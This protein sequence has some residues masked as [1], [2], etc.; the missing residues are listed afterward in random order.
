MNLFSLAA[1]Q[2]HEQIVFCH[3]AESGLKA[4]IG[5]HDTTLGPALGGCRM[6]PYQSEEAALIDVLRLSRGMTYKNAVMGLSHGGGK[7]VIIGDPR[8]DKSPQLWQAFGRF[9]Q[10]LGGRYI[11][12]EDVGVSVDD[13]EH[14][15]ATTRWV[16]GRAGVS[17]DP[18]P[19]TAFGVYRGIKAAARHALGDDS[20]QGLS[21]AV[22]GLGKVGRHLCRHLAAEGAR[23]VVAD[24]DPQAVAETVAAYGAAAVAADAVV[25]AAVDI[26]SP[27]ALGAVINDATVD[28][29][30]CRIVAGAANNQL[31]E[32]R[33]GEELRR[34]GILYAPDFVINGGGV[35]N[36]AEEFYPGGYNRERV[37]ARVA[38]IYDKLLHI[39]ATSAG[40][41]ICTAVA[42]ER[43]AEERIRRRR[44]RLQQQVCG[45]D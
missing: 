17:G 38:A 31:A 12:A 11:T 23:L 26:F 1:D 21:I 29:L 28:R 8:T 6:W 18:S 41:G 7:A 43:L 39:F 5:I 37:W 14:V 20:L 2:G 30:R 25:D 3:D 40:A 13:M 35:I 44:S 15:A 32:A 45:D 10:G 24:L 36:V 16:V 42:A 9:V 22:Q 19:V 4:I 27:C 34:R 33:H